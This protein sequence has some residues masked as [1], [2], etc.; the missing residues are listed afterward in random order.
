MMFFTIYLLNYA[1]IIVSKAI[2]QFLKNLSKTHL[3]LNL[4][5][6]RFSFL[7]RNREINKTDITK[8]FRSPDGGPTHQLG[9]KDMVV[10]HG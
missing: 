6:A 5:G 7:K 2:N 10:L 8:K 4:H 9:A 1:L 3:H